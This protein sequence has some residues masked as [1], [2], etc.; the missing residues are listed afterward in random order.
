LEACKGVE[1]KRICTWH[2]K[3]VLKNIKAQKIAL[4]CQLSMLK[5]GSQA[6][7]FALDL[8]WIPQASFSGAP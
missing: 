2:V 8:L 5:I 1:H 7:F 3:N 6:F 4:G